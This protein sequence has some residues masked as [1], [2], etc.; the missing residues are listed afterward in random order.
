MR[1]QVEWNVAAHTSRAFGPDQLLHPLPHLGGGLVGKGDGQDAPG[2]NPPAQQVGDR[3]GIDG[4]RAL[5]R[6]PQG[7]EVVRRH[8]GGR[9][10]IGVVLR[11]E[12]D[13]V[14]DAVGDH[15]GLAAARPGQDEQRPLAVQHRL[16]L[17]LVEAGKQ[18]A[19]HR[20]AQTLVFTNRRRVKHDSRSPSS[21]QGDSR[22][23][24][25][26]PSSRL[27]RNLRQWVPACQYM[28]ASV[29]SRLPVLIKWVPLPGENIR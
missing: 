8:V 23:S 18:G 6:G 17:L 3:G 21:R 5:D 9:R 25:A 1:T 7:R 28:A 27:F 13:E 19:A 24:A 11:P 26:P 15:A 2:G 16:P 10:R 12:E 20:F 4:P 22:P 29:D 14:G